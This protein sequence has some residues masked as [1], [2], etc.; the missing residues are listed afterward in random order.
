MGAAI[1][2][3]TLMVPICQRLYV[4]RKR[5]KEKT[6]VSESQRLNAGVPP[7]VGRGAGTGV[8]LALGKHQ[9]DSKIAG[10][11]TRRSAWGTPDHAPGRGRKAEPIWR[12]PDMV[13]RLRARV[14]HALLSFSGSSPGDKELKEKPKAPLGKCGTQHDR[15]VNAVINVRLSIHVTNPMLPPGRGPMLRDGPALAIL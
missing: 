7:Q 3:R 13:H 8:K 15:S 4:R 14:P 9:V 1:N 5:P 11:R 10:P 12:L 2:P 6:P